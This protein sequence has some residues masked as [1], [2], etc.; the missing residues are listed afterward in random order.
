MPSNEQAGKRSPGVQA[1]APPFA[2]PPT[3][4]PA[5]VPT[6]NHTTQFRHR[7]ETG[8]KLLRTPTQALAALQTP[9]EPFTFSKV[10]I[11]SIDLFFCQRNM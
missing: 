2:A 4:K 10:I 6:T 3:L 11:I 1:P 5:P 8:T 7:N 9:H